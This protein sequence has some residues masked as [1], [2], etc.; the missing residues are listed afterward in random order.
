MSDF[1]PVHHYLPHRAPMLLLDEL[2][3]VDAE[4][5]H[6]RVTVSRTGVLAPF[7]NAAGA[8]PAW[9]GLEIMAQ[10]VAVWSGWHQRQAGAQDIA[11][12]ML[13]GARRFSAKVPAFAAGVVLDVH[14]TLLARDERIGGFEADI[15]QGDVLLAQARL[16]TCQVAAHELAALFE[17][18]SS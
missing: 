15:R 9:F 6:C 17:R 18:G 8:V 5:C 16:S 13:L 2:R 12:G 7:L 1:L 11:L 3:A 4:T 14:V 10:A